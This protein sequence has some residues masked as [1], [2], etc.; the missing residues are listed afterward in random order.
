MTLVYVLLA[1]VAGAV[2]WGHWKVKEHK[3]VWGGAALGAIVGLV[4]ALVEGDP[5]LLALSYAAGTFAATAFEGI[6]KIVKRLRAG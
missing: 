4:V 3:A 1:I 6:G 2:L 5:G